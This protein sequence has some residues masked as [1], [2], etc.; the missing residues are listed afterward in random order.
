MI[1]GHTPSAD[2]QRTLATGGA[3][4]LYPSY[5]DK[6]QITL[7]WWTVDQLGQLA[8]SMSTPSGA[9]ARTVTLDAVLDRPEHPL[10]FGVFMSE[11]TAKS[12][13]L[14][15][16]DSMILASTTSM[17]TTAQTDALELAVQNLPDN[18]QG[19]MY[20]HIERG[21]TPFAQP[22]VWGLLGLS[23]LIA[24]AA[25]AVAIGLARFDG[26]QDDA[27]LSSL[28]AGRRVRRN[29]AFC[30]ALVI[31]GVGAV[32][33]AGLGLVPAL[34]LR[35]NADTPFAP[36][37]LQIGL[38]A[39]ALPLAIACGSWLFTSRSRVSARRVTIA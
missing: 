16:E 3:V 9:P 34:A 7:S 27:T 2:A 32:L 37:W 5:L 29:F 22:W 33:G 26:R 24:I 36:P 35:A 19:M 4:S 15:Y 28:G 17:P 8:R 20:V 18:R 25:S 11:H 6:G 14:D 10:Y 31:S 30:Q 13:G 38:T 1:L 23:G 12:I 21:P 39:V